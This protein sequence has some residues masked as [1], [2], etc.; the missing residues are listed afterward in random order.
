MSIKLDRACR[1]TRHLPR[2]T[3]EILDSIPAELVSRLTSRELALVMNALDKH[4]HKARAFESREIM[5]DGVAYS[6][7]GYR[8]LGPFTPYPSEPT[9]EPIE[10]IMERLSHRSAGTKDA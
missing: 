9:H 2:A 1:L 4:W 5:S 7:T 8:E 3:E 10:S 6:S